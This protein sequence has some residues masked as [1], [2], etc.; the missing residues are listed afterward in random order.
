MCLNSPAPTYPE[1]TNLPISKSGTSCSHMLHYLQLYIVNPVGMGVCKF[2]IVLVFFFFF[3]VL[4][5]EYEN[6]LDCLT[7]QPHPD[8]VLLFAVPVCAPYTALSNYKYI[9]SST[10]MY[11]SYSLHHCIQ[12]NVCKKKTCIAGSLLHRDSSRYTVRSLKKTIYDILYF[13]II[14]SLTFPQAQSE[15]DS[16][17]TEERERYK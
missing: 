13:I 8:D 17:D 15:I 9:C 6:F 3:F 14:M 2:F 4:F 10:I 5:Q 7:G 1:N 11:L 12:Q 16:W